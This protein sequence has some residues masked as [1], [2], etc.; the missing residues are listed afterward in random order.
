MGGQIARAHPN[1]D[2]SPRVEPKFLIEDGSRGHTNLLR[3]L[4][5][6]LQMLMATVGLILLIA[7]ANVA[8]LLLARA[9]TRQK[10]IAIR[11][12][13]GAGRMRLIRQLLTESVLLST[14]GG[15]AGLALAASISGMMV[16]FTPPNNNAFSSL[17]LD[18]R[19]DMRVLGFTLVDLGGHRYPLRPGAGARRLSAG[20]GV[21][22]AGRGDGLWKKGCAI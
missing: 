3:D 6:P 19:L 15:A 5:F 11:L 20:P 4:R 14:L 1:P 18:N 8:N 12:A 17:T 7:C 9:G 13:T 21:R 16:S 2:G 10:E 22:S